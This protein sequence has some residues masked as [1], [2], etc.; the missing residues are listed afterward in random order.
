ME[1]LTEEGRQLYELLKVSA[2][3]AAEERVNN[4]RSTA[5]QAMSQLIK[6]N[7]KRFSDLNSKVDDA[8]TEIRGALG[9]LGTAGSAS[10]SPTAATAARATVTR[11]SLEAAEGQLGHRVDTHGRRSG[12]Y[13]PPPARGTRDN[14]SSA[15]L[16]K[17]G[18]ENF[19][20]CTDHFTPGPRVELPRFDGVQPRLWQSRCEEYFQL[21][22]TPSSLWV[23]YVSAQFDGAA[24]KWLEAYKH[25][26]P[27]GSWDDFCLAHQARF[28]RNQ[29]ATLLRRMFHV[30]Q[31]TTVEAYVEEFSQLM[32]QLS[33]YGHHPDPL[34]YVT[35][36]MDGLQAS[37]RLMVAIQLPSDLDTAYQL[38][39]LHEELGDGSTPFNSTALP[40]KTYGA[41]APPVKPATAD[42]I[43]PA[44]NKQ[45]G[46]DKWVA[47]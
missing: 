18:E 33:A 45:A 16:D 26:Y 25:K 11:E 15:S 3:E 28:G 41:Y 12:L 42:K 21:W 7:D 2:K 24:A 31:S 23:P 39:L 34:Y 36:F 20:E 30:R 37:V 38:A 27:Q 32:D 5:T 22:G 1:S 4:Y 13:I 35:R 10:P 6:D 43:P 40:K 19:V 14:L 46:E 29:H 44:V 8:M 47:L 9:K 17:S